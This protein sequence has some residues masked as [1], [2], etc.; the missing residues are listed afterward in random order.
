ML[1]NELRVRR[2]SAVV[3]GGVRYHYVEA[4]QGPLLLLLHG[5]PEN[6]WSWRYQIEPLAR[7]G[8]RVVAPDLRGFNHSD[9]RGP[10]D[11][12]TMCADV[13]GLIAALGAERASV[14]G[15]DWGGAVAWHLASFRPQLV[16]RVVVINCP[17]P[18]RMAVALRSSWRQIMRSWYMFFAQVPLLPEWSLLH[19]TSSMFAR[20]YARD[21]ARF[22]E[23]ELRPFV[24]GLH[25]PGAVHAMLGWCRAEFWGALKRRGAIPAYP[26]IAAEVLLLWGGKDFVLGYEDLVPGTKRY[27]PKL[28]IEVVESGGHFVHAEQPDRVNQALIAF[29]TVGRPA[30]AAV[31][32][33][34]PAVEAE[35]PAVEA[36]A[37]AVEAEAPAV[38]AEAPA[39]EAEAPAVEAEAPAV[40]AEAPAVEAEAPAVEPPLEQAFVEAPPPPPAPPRG[41]PPRTAFTVVLADAGE[42]KIGVIRELRDITGLDV[43]QARALIDHVPRTIRENASWRDAERIRNQ[44]TAAGATVEIT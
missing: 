8:F 30:E 21:G 18:A 40:E 15:H 27:A 4:G 42:N 26:P 14:V 20:M 23:E 7:A 35:A 32:A 19:V 9:K 3:G 16:D 17:H 2:G 11:L 44:L 39:V 5:F 25:K 41:P 6:H 24:E 28:R 22:P 37:P 36:E 43:R 12:D 33:E 13:G 38:E 29:L 34:A 31:E 10:Y 1:P